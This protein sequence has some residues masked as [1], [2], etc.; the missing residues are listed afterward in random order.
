MGCANP[1]GQAGSAASRVAGTLGV[2]VCPWRTPVT[3]QQV[4]KT[5]QSL[6]KKTSKSLEGTNLIVLSLLLSLQI[7]RFPIHE[8]HARKDLNILQ[9]IIKE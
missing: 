4:K 5:S 1:A 9:Q 6:G 2:G 8:F 3:P 7:S